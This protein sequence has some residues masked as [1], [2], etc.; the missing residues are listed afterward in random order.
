MNKWISADQLPEPFKDVL[1]WF[2]YYRYGDY[3]CMFQT[4]GLGY[5]LDDK[6][7]DFVNHESGWHKL[8]IIAWQPLPEP[9]KED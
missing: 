3:N 1:V 4:Y 6:W 7:S 2:E 8:K 5:A 9:P